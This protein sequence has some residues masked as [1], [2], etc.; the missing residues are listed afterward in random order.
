MSVMTGTGNR[1]PVGDRGGE[2]NRG[3]NRLG[4]GKADRQRA[5]K[6]HVEPV[7]TGTEAL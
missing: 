7:R 4:T 5:G 1:G 3:G 2:R 6:A